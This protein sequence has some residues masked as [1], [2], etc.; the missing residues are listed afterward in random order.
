MDSGKNPAQMTGSALQEAAQLEKTAVFSI[1]NGTVLCDAERDE[2]AA[3]VYIRVLST[4]AQ[5]LPDLDF[6]INCYDEPRVLLG[7]GTP[8]D[9]LAMACKV[10]IA[11]PSSRQAQI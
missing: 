7:Q 2:P 11:G 8:L 1:R 6:V 5:H 4:V 10:S 3:A 9:R